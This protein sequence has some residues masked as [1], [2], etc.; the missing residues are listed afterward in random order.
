MAGEKKIKL[1]FEIGIRNLSKDPL[2][3]ATGLIITCR[4]VIGHWFCGLMKY[5]YFLGLAVD[6]IKCVCHL[7]SDPIIYKLVLPMK[8]IVVRSTS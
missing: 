1:N 3:L 8:T 6:N 2:C 7:F 4:L 5:S